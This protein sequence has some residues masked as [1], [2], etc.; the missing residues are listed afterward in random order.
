MLAKTANDVLAMAKEN[1]VRF[2]E[3][4]LI[5]ILGSQKT[6]SIPV[7]QLDKA[8][9]NEIAFDGSSIEGFVRIN[10]A[11]ML[12]YPDP[13]TFVIYP[14][15]SGRQTTARLLC[16][17]HNPDGTPFA[18]DPR[19]VLKKVVKEAEAMGFQ[20][21]AGT[22]AEF[23]LFEQGENGCPTVRTFDK[24]YYFDTD[25]T[26]KSEEARRDMVITLEEMGFSI[27]AAHHEN[28]HGQHE[29]DFKYAG[30]IET[31]DN[32]ATLKTVVR[33]VARSHGMHATFMPKPIAGV[34]GSGMHIH[35]SVFQ[36]GV[37]A[38]YDEKRPQGLS[39]M[40]E[41]Y[42]AGLMDHAGAMT[43]I[44]NQLVNSYKRLVP[45]HEAPVYIAWAMANRSPLI[46]IPSRRGIGT[47]IELRSPDC[48]CNPYL[49]LAVSMKAGLDGIKR[50]LVPPAPI[51][52]NIYELDEKQRQIR[53]ILSLPGDL[54]QAMDALKA[55]ALMRETLGEHVF[56]SFLNAK[57]QEWA[58]YSQQVHEWELNRYLW[59]F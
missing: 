41:S 26:D 43:A 32:I 52:D 23:F 37:N 39:R 44:T 29:I 14:W 59:S 58:D 17:V 45:G 22:E 11:D 57:S 7:T 36:N 30:A 31:A 28:A 6:V 5:D 46:R 35:Q 9:N 38:F 3:L 2:V 13:N 56:Q 12:L 27:E 1:N 55:D 19:G 54:N 21:C 18:G 20:L 51:S 42:I 33:I 49:A 48:S 25:P 47:R 16:D 53:N 40:A 34:A 15:L 10:E 24:G 50:Q 8:L 4:Q